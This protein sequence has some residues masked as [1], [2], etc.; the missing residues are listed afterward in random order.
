MSALKIGNL[1]K[2]SNCEIVIIFD[3]SVEA[4]RDH[5]NLKAIYKILTTYRFPMSVNPEN[6]F[7]ISLLSK[8]DADLLSSN[9]Q[10]FIKRKI[11]AI[12]PRY[13]VVPVPKSLYQLAYIRSLFERLSDFTTEILTIDQRY[14]QLDS[15]FAAKKLTPNQYDQLASQ[16]DKNSEDASLPFKQWSKERRKLIFDWS[17]SNDIEYYKYCKDYL[18][19]DAVINE[20]IQFNYI[21]S[22][23]MKNYELN[24]NSIPVLV[25]KMAN[26]IFSIIESNKANTDI[27][28][29]FDQQSNMFKIIHKL[30]PQLSLIK[31]IINLEW[32]FKDKPYCVIYRGVET[33][34]G[35]NPLISSKFESKDFPD[36]KKMNIGFITNQEKQHPLTLSY[37]DG[38]FGGFYKDAISGMCFSYLVTKDVAGMAVLVSN[39][40]LKPDPDFIFLPPIPALAAINGNFEF[41]HPRSKLPNL[42]QSFVGNPPYGVASTGAISNSKAEINFREILVSN[43]FNDISTFDSS[44]REFLKKRTIFIKESNS[45]RSKKTSLSTPPLYSFFDITQ[46]QNET[47]QLLHEE[48][49]S[50]NKK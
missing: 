49:V 25:E 30:D 6:Q 16:L 17:P 22:T 45:L 12:D 24:E 42:A 23:Y 9:E 1:M 32:S 10:E 46:K 36:F 35:D 20:W 27:F 31:N 39:N 18:N 38:I 19:R 41:H 48:I 3:P 14:S 7:E 2:Y 47:R 8:D 21:I 44:L 5:Q 15:D 50:F 29:S 28:E 11:D 26:S 4:L 34:Y 43:A 13:Q 37:S 33:S 40:R